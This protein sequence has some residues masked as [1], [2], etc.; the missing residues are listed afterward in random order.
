[1]IPKRCKCC[2]QIL[3]EHKDKRRGSAVTGGVVSSKEAKDSSEQRK[4]RASIE[5]IVKGKFKS[6]QAK[7][8]RAM[9]KAPSRKETALLKVSLPR[10]PIEDDDFDASEYLRNLKEQ[11]PMFRSHAKALMMKPGKKISPKR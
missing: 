2:G 5:K 9:L 4:V 8:L 10:L 3:L 11:S 7:K 6:K 1:M